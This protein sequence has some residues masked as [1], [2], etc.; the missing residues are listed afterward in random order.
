MSFHIFDCSIKC[1]NMKHNRLSYHQYLY[2][3]AA[4]QHE[5]AEHDLS[6]LVTELKFQNLTGFVDVDKDR[7]E[8][9]SID[10][11]LLHKRFEQ[12]IQG[13]TAPFPAPLVNLYS[14]LKSRLEHEMLRHRVRP[15]SEDFRL[16]RDMAYQR[17]QVS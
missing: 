12:I 8:I 2:A 11:A 13:T 15:H 14:S 10:V 3:I 16:L 7:G 1:S 9:N 17:A 5:S 4:A 6:D